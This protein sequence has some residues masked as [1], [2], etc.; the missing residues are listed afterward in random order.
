[1]EHL[2]RPWPGEPGRSWERLT[3]AIETYQ[4][5]ADEAARLGFGDDAA[6]Y[7]QLAASATH[8]LTRL[9]AWDRS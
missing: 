5:A 3:S 4:E 2:H 9:T 6:H 8:R 1:M 7:Q